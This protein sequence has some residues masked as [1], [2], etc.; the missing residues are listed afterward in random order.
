M[1]EFFDLKEKY[2]FEVTDLTA[3]IYTICAV[4]GI[5][6]ANVTVLFF[7]GS[8][9]ATAFCWQAHKINVIVLN[10]ALFALNLVNFLKLFF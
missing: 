8:V 6:G 9:I 5:M 2:K 7:V 3:L 1:K 4:L 10:V